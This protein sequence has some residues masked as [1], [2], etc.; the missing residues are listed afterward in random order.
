MRSQPATGCGWNISKR[1]MDWQVTF[2]P[3]G[4]KERAEPN[5]PP[6]TTKG[7]RNMRSQL[8]Q[9]LAKD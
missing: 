2:R 1:W 3:V 7:G 5:G 9:P 8:S 6:K 4:Q